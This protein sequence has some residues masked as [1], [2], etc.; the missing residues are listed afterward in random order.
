MSHISMCLN[1]L[2]V[3]ENT[4]LHAGGVALAPVVSGSQA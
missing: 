1:L 3:G 4:R 2:A